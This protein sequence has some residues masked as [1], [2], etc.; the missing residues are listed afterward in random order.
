MSAEPEQGDIAD[1]AV[2]AREWPAIVKLKHP[3]EF[4]DA[5]I[6]S[7]TFRRGR[8]G[9]LKGITP[10]ACPRSISSCSSHRGCAG[11]RSR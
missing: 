7:L 11:S 3:F 4:D 1:R 9:D 6:E 8:M 2:A 5:R 10:T